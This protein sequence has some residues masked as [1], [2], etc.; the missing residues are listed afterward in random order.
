MRIETL[1]QGY[2]RAVI[3]VV[4]GVSTPALEAVLQAQVQVYV[5]QRTR[6]AT[7]PPASWIDFT[8]LQQKRL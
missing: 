4:G 1:L 5:P 6:G 2:E 3:G 8:G 7:Q